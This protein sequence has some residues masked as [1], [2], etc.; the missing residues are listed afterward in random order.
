MTE[1]RRTVKKCAVAPF[2]S[3]S[4]QF[5]VL[6][7]HLSMAH[8]AG[9]VALRHPHDAGEHTTELGFRM[10]CSS[11]GE[12]ENESHV[13]IHMSSNSFGTP[14]TWKLAARACHH[15]CQRLV[16]SIQLIHVCLGHSVPLGPMLGRRCTVVLGC[17]LR[18]ALQI[19]L[20]RRILRLLGRTS[21]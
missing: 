8:L 21:R 20:G 16:A 13:A 9:K 15:Y 18:Q 10:V 11:P 3:V 1:V 12:R 4:V 5:L 14:P 19:L 17:G 6:P 7:N 2:I